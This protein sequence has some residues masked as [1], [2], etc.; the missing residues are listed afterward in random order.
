MI[1]WKRQL[2]LFVSVSFFFFFFFCS[3]RKATNCTFSLTLADQVAPLVSE[4]EACAAH[5]G[6]GAGSRTKQTPISKLKSKDAHRTEF[7]VN[8]LKIA[9]KKKEDASWH[10]HTLVTAR[11][12]GRQTHEDTERT[13]TEWNEVCRKDICEEAF[14]RGW[15]RRVLFKHT[16]LHLTTQSSKWCSTIHFNCFAVWLA[17]HV[18]CSCRSSCQIQ[19]DRKRF[20]SHFRML[21]E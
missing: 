15:A 7:L 13:V 11:H 19:P 16:L 4:L 9:K 2:H 10:T 8:N 20:R 5:F 21:L 14:W 12:T 3:F 17:F 6:C 1:C 18:V